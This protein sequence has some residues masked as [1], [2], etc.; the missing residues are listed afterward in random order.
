MDTSII[1]FPQRGHWGNSSWRGNASGH[2]YKSLFEQLRPKVFIDPMEGSG[3]SIQVAKEM[4]IECY[5]LD[6]HSGFN[7][8]KHSILDVVGKPADL[9]FSHPPY[10]SM[11]TYSGE[12]WGDAPHPDDLSRCESDSDFHEKMQLVLLN[13]RRA[14]VPDGYYGTLIGDWRRGGIYTSYQAEMICRLPREELAAVIIKAQH[15]CVSDRKS[16]G[17]MTMPRVMHEFVLLWKKKSA[18]I[19]VLLAGIVRDQSSR[20]TGTWKNIVRIVLTGL[21]GSCSL[22]RLY[23]AIE[24]EA[25]DR[26]KTNAHWKEKIRQTLNSNTDVFKSVER[27]VWAIA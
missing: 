10:G 22:D 27:G 2:V 11:I 9:V 6:L 16:Y 15:N 1:S 21:G 12:V 23:R 14:T 19:L 4:N 26:L 8:I 7:A 20:T 18:P 17:R 24:H 5:G 3:T 13:Q 25:P